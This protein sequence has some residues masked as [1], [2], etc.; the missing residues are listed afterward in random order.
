MDILKPRKPT[1]KRALTSAASSSMASPSAV[2][3]SP[4]FSS[5]TMTW[6]SLAGAGSPASPLCRSPRSAASLACTRKYYT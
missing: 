5:G 4:A 1:L 2:L 6:Y 3:S